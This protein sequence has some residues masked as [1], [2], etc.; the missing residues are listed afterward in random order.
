M[1]CLCIRREGG[2]EAEGLN[3][4]SIYRNQSSFFSWLRTLESIRPRQPHDMVGFPAG[5]RPWSSTRG[6]APTR[7]IQKLGF[8]SEG[9][10]KVLTCDEGPLEAQTWVLW[11][12]RV[13][14]GRACG[15]R[16]CGRGQHRE[17]CGLDPSSASC[18]IHA[19]FW[20]SELCPCPAMPG[21]C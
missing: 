19:G 5:R 6:G 20:G 13:C 18:S 7:Y 16:A 10:K 12:G 21:F 14:G 2:T 11:D 4:P 3:R 8:P 1:S 9:L 15:G 17:S